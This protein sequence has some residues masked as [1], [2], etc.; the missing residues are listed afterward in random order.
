MLGALRELGLGPSTGQGPPMPALAAEALARATKGRMLAMG[1]TFILGACLCLFTS[2]RGNPVFKL[3][4][5]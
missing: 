5:F 3:C 4:S 1:F 2:I